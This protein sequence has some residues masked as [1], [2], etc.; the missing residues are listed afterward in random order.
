ME[1]IIADAAIVALYISPFLLLLGLCGY[2]AD[3]VLP[4]YP[5]L[6]RFFERL[7]DVDLGGSD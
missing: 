4:R 3:Y 7:F 6:L 5:R 1:N 2:L